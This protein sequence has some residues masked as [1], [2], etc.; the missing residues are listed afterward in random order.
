MT[1]AKDRDSRRDLA[2]VGPDPS[3]SRRRLISIDDLDGYKV[4]SGEPDIRGWDVATLNGR[5]LGSVEDLLVDPD[6]GE[7]V[8]VEVALRGDKLHA[9]VPLRSVQLDRKRKVV[10]V[11]SGD[12]ESGTHHDVR[13]RDRLDRDERDRM[14]STYTDPRDVR[15]DSGD[16]R[17]V[18]D[19]A[20]DAARD[21]DRDAGRDADRDAD[22]DESVRL[23]QA[24][25]Q[26]IREEEERRL[27]AEEE[28]RVR[29][30]EAQRRDE[31]S[32]RDERRR[33]DD[34]EE[35]VVERRPVIEEVVVRRRVIDE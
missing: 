8:M 24:E 9:E 26:R 23:R 33:D 17:S 12:I 14:R 20:R 16:D 28:R 18:R 29:E 6:R 25:E 35:T 15:Y 34:V 2:G 1:M 22:H 11:D 10:I 3:E 5:E 32:R 27:R 4:A 19:A 21:A 31:E 13:A 7:V 30:A